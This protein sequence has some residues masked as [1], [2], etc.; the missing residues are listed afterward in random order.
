MLALFGLWNKR[1]F[2]DDGIQ[3][4]P[5]DGSERRGRA[6]AL[7]ELSAIWLESFPHY[8]NPGWFSILTA[9]RV[10]GT[11]VCWNGWE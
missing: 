8:Q 9:L 4:Q 11:R 3:E 10:S 1:D 6:V 7:L 2:L 5:V